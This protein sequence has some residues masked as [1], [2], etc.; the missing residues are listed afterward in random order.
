MP[1]DYTRRTPRAPRTTTTPVGEPT[2]GRIDYRKAGHPAPRVVAAEAP[3]VVPNST[4]GYGGV[5][6]RPG[7][8]VPMRAWPIRNA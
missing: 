6:L 7:E 4:P 2:P 5:V 3:A 1:I 8:S